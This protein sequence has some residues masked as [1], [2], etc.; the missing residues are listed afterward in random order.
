MGTAIVLGFQ[1]LGDGKAAINGDFAITADEVNPVIQ[2][3]RKNDIQVVSLHNHMLE[4]T[5][6]LYFM[7]F[8]A[9][10]GATKLAKGLRAGLDKATSG[11][12]G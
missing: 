4:E 5:P 3:L 11:G 12:N 9:T 2:A 10:G 6:D 8:W 1:P 7:H